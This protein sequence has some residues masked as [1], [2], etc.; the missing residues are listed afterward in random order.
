VNAVLNLLLLL[1]LLPQSFYSPL[2]G[3]TRRNIHPLIYPDRH[4]TF[5]SFLHL[6]QTIASSLF[7][8][9]A[10][11]SFCTPVSRSCLVYLLVWSP[12]PHT[13]YISLPNQCLLFATHAH[14]IT[15][16]FAVVPRLFNAGLKRAASGSLK[17]QDTKNRH[18][19]T[20]A[21]LCWAISL[22]LTH[23]STIGKKTC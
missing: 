7:N 19:G 9:R 15:T 1:L 12:P 20:I 17:I 18:L 22:Q 2:S 21:Q 8:I 3:T 6:L 13:P 16:Y 14:T 5:I 23:V 10:W 4:P 11:Q